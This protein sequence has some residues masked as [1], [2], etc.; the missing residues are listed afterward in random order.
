MYAIRSYYEIFI[1]KSWGAAMR[2]YKFEEEDVEK[3]IKTTGFFENR[4]RLFVK[5]IGT[6]IV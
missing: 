5:E 6:G 3:Y 4:V 2:Y 1:V